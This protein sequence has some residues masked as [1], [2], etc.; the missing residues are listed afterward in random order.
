MEDLKGKTLRGGVARLLA[1]GAS[2]A[3]RV[4]SIVILAR[5]LSPKD[6][7]LMGMVTAF[8]GILTLFRDFGLSAASIHRPNISEE[9]L[10][11][12]FWI[13][14]LV[15]VLLGIITVIM[16]PAIAAFYH[17]P[18]LLSVSAVMALA[19]VFN[20][21]GL[22]HGVILQREMRYTAL[23]AIFTISQLIGTAAAI[24]GAEMG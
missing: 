17:E 9:Q 19:F 7:G 21:A 4:G 2:F 20:S 15:G 18:R 12:L 22:Q 24:R 23:A 16:S 6:F 3:I 10:S 13:N 11:T 5:L 14:L 1:Q 8:T